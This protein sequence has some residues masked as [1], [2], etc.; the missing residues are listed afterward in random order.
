[1]IIKDLTTLKINKLT[2][3]Q[4]DA[5]LAAGTINEN[6]LYIKEDDGFSINNTASALEASKWNNG[7][8]DLS[9]QYPNSEY[10]VEISLDS[11]ATNAQ[12]SAYANAKM[13]GSSTTNQLK[14]FGLVPTIDIPVFITYYKI[15]G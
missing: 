12:Y 2:K 10:N 13:V 9:D 8:Y 4:Y 7:V 11:T 6:E 1:M 3:K 15:G 14:A 5:A